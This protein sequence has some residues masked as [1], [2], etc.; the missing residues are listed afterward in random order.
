MAPGSLPGRLSA[1]LP[2][3]EHLLRLQRSIGNQAVGQLV[4]GFPIQRKLEE[5]DAVAFRTWVRTR[6]KVGD[7]GAVP[8][9]YRGPISGI[10]LKADALD[11]AK[12][13]YEAAVT[14][15]DEIGLKLREY[16]REL[17][18]GPKSDKD[19][20]G[21]IDQSVA[22]ASQGAPGALTLET[23]IA[24]FDKIRKQPKAPAFERSMPKL[25][26]ARDK[27]ALNEE[28][29]GEG[30]PAKQVVKPCVVM[31]HED[32]ALASDPQYVIWS[33]GAGAC[34][35]LGGWSEKGVAYIKHSTPDDVLMGAKGV[36]TA[37]LRELGPSVKTLFVASQ[38]VAGNPTYLG[39]LREALDAKLKIGEFQAHA[40][41]SMAINARTGQF[42]VDFNPT[43][44][45]KPERRSE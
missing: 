44:L 21:L 1:A 45:P 4:R 25:T 17:T 32:R 36:A 10:I 9:R 20:N 18:D 28:W 38:I 12:A 19:L 43:G 40:A 16:A 24:T 7:L 6:F 11:E 15:I 26:L 13:M 41:S 39:T 22:R 34:I 31:D 30:R 27:P 29:F 35:I 23:A 42:Q 8:A 14:A 5:H 37:L 2:S 33:G 3:T